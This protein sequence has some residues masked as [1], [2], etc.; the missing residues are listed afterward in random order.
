MTVICR[1]DETEFLK[2]VD[3]AAILKTELLKGFV[4][5]KEFAAAEKRH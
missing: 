3:S 1:Y 2:T 5:D 4:L